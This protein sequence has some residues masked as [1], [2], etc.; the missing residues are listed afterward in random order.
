MKREKFLEKISQDERV[1]K[2]EYSKR[3]GYIVEIKKGYGVL[4]TSSRTE[5]IKDTYYDYCETS[6]LEVARESSQADVEWFLSKVEK[7]NE[8]DL[9]KK[10]KEQKLIGMKRLYDYTQRQ[11]YRTENEIK[12]LS[13][14]KSKLEK[15]KNKLDEVVKKFKEE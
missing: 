11:I 8:E 2:I 10:N 12:S 1:E 6:I 3:L 13:E 4:N 9:I 7:I 5:W 14:Y 15:R